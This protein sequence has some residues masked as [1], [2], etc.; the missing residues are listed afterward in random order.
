[1]LLGAQQVC[2]HLRACHGRAGRDRE[3]N[4]QAVV[5][6]RAIL[7]HLFDLGLHFRARL[8]GWA[9]SGWVVYPISVLAEWITPVANA[10]AASAPNR[11]AR[12]RELETRIDF[13]FDR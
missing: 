5:L 7:A 2:F 13:S 8:S 11:V 12:M 1:M 9:C 4:A 10:G 6:P 3:R